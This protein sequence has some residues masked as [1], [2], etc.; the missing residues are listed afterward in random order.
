MSKARLKGES[1][2]SDL[3]KSVRVDVA[4]CCRLIDRF[5]FD[6]LTDGFVAGRVQDEDIIIGG[7][8]VLPGRVTAS[9]LHS[10]KLSDE[11]KVVWHGG[12]DYDALFFS[13]TIFG[14]RHDYHALIHAHPDKIMTFAA[15]DAEIEPI[16]QAGIM[17][18]GRVARLSFDGDVTAPNCRDAIANAFRN[19]KEAVLLDNHG[20]LM[21]G[22]TIADAFVK[23]YRFEQ[24]CRTQLAAMATGQPLVYPDRAQLPK[25]SE[26]YWHNDAYVQND[27]S[28]E[29][30]AFLDQLTNPPADFRS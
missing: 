25:W 13:K 2:V 4:A 21:P 28:R 7:Y 19:G 30:D 15:I 23:L 8:G 9:S 20:I 24:A 18:Y 6:D 22:R 26:E 14:V 5:G 10:A 27:G 29:W 11:P 1:S 17:F 3:E 12:I 16:S